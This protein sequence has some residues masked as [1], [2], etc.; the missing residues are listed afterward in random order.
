MTRADAPLLYQQVAHVVAEQIGSGTLRAGDR[1]PSVRNLSRSAG[2]SIAT[3]TQAYHELERRGLLEARPRSGYFVAAP[4]ALPVPAARTVRSTRPRS[5]AAEAMDAIIESLSRTDLVA[6]QS[7]IAASAHGVNA[8]LNR[9]TREVL[10]R[11]PDLPNR[12]IAPPGDLGLRREIARRMGL[13]GIATAPDDVVIT[14]GALDAIRLSL[15]ALCCAGDAVLIETPTYFGILQLVEQLSLK[16]VEVPNRPGLGIDVDAVERLVASGT[17]L[18]AAVLMPN[19]NN[20]TGA[21]TSDADKAR[22]LRLLGGR[23]IPVIEDDVYGDLALGGRRPKPL[24]AF[25]G[26]TV[27]TCGSVSKSLALGYR[28]GWAVSGEHAPEIARHQFVSS[29]AVPGLQQAVLARYFAAGGY[30]RHL[31]RVRASLAANAMR[32]TE[33][34]ARYFPPGTRVS[35]PAGGVVLWVQLPPAVDGVALFHHA[36]AERIGIAPGAIFS[37]TG[38]YRSFIRLSFGVAWSAAVDEAL[39][40]LG[41]L[42]TRLA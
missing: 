42:T 30:E 37:A 18:A 31:D 29:V 26:A 35:A 9:L 14:A 24:G 39:R 33:A 27:I 5:V 41:R 10:R 1:A 2:V 34:I 11:M 32:F 23:G 20:P 7:A 3:V 36:L 25:G 6:L 21:V 17:P 16:F 12:L 28:I 19:F 40:V 13:L 8:R 22:L 4:A 38:G 15:R